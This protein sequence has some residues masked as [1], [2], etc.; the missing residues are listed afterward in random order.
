MELALNRCALLLT[1]FSAGNGDVDG[2]LLP[3]VAHIGRAGKGDVFW[4]HTFISKKFAHF[5]LEFAPG[6]TKL[7]H[8]H[9][10]GMHQFGPHQVV[11]QVAHQHA[12]GGEVSWGERNNDTWHMHISCQRA[13]MQPPPPKATM[14]N[15]RG[16]RPC[17]TETNLSRWIILA[18]A[19]RMMPRD[20]SS[21]LT[22]NGRA[23]VATASRARSTSR[24]ML[25]PRKYS[26][27][28]RPTIML[29]SV[30]VGWVPPR[31]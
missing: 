10:R 4:P 12:P 23:M 14:A 28:I 7:G 3:Q 1:Q 22:P 19:M 9:V 13:C 15:S 24:R 16:S 8:L 11:S 20:A 29:A 27:L 6:G 26:G 21:M 25:P 18:L 5:L 31:P 30:T 17:R 2:V